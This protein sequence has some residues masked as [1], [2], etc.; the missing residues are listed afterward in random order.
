MFQNIVNMQFVVVLGTFSSSHA[1]SL[2]SWVGM[3][4]FFLFSHIFGSPSSLF[5]APPPSTLF[6]FSTHCDP[7][8]WHFLVLLEALPTLE[9]VNWQPGGLYQAC[10]YVW[11]GSCSAGSH[12]VFKNFWISCQHWNIGIFHIKIW[13]PRFLEEFGNTGLAGELSVG[14]TF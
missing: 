7:H 2:V 3:L 10:R 12:S 8:P 6:F 5:L 14:D 9:F 11:F 4:A 1:K 13:I